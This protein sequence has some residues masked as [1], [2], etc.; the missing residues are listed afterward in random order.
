MLIWSDVR[1]ALRLLR[2]APGVTVIAV[3]S[4]ALSIGALAAVFTAV[5][6][7]LLE[8]LPYAHPDQLVIFDGNYRNAPEAQ[9]D[10]VFKREAQEILRRSRTLEGAGF[11]RNAVF[12]LG[13]DAN[14]PPEAL[15]GLQMTASVLPALGVTPLLGRNIAKSEEP[16]T[17]A[18]MI[19]SYGL[20]M[21][22]F[23]GDRGVVGRTVTVNGRACR[24]IGVMGPEFNF[25]LR[26]EAVRTP[27]PYVEF[28]A[29]M[30]IEKRSP[31]DGLQ[32][33][34][35]LK[36]GS[37]L[38]E[39]QQDVRAI[40]EALAREFPE[41]DGNRILRISRLR[42]RA[43]GPAGKALWLL[44]GAAGM[45]LLIGCAN[46]ASLLLARGLGRQREIA[47]RVALGASGGRI[48]R[49]LLTEGCVLAVLGGVAGYAVA[50]ASWWILPAMAPRTIPRLA[51][52]QA[53][54]RVL[55]FALGAAVLNGLLFGLA[56]AVRA[57]RGGELGARGAAT[58]RRDWLRADLIAAEVAITVTLVITGG[59]LLGSFLALL[60]IDPGFT[61]D[62]VLAAVVLPQPDRYREPAARSLVYRRFLEAARTIPGVVSAG[63]VDA[64]PFSGENDGG[65]LTTKTED[66]ANRKWQMVAE[67]DTIG[68][69]YLAT[70]GARLEEGRW[71]HDEEKD[72]AI[73]TEMTARKLWPGES[74]L[75]KRVCVSCTPEQ[76][77]NWKRVVGITSN[78]R[79]LGLEGEAEGS[80]FLA[81]NAMRRGQFLVIRTERPAG[82]YQQALRR[83]VASVEPQ[84][85][86]LL[87]ASMQTLVSDSLAARRFLML[88][89]AATGCLALALSA[90]GIYGVTAYTTSR[91]TQEI[92]IRMALGATPRNVHALVFRQGFA[93]VA[94]GLAIGFG[95]TAAA[96]R[97]LQAWLPGLTGGGAGD[98]WLAIAIVVSAAALACWIPSRRATLVDP[99][100]ALRVE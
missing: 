78:M 57:S 46:V 93:T 70:M 76:P 100:T 50:V 58:A 62:R 12:D 44:M 63:T 20:W 79:H 33:V 43:I 66:I 87:S 90:A 28:W 60:R 72:T 84:Q 74:A 37:T 40:S 6:A 94:V 18:E 47:I 25:P 71:F 52:A 82:E 38:A 95:I 31:Q 27:Q 36:P 2:R 83:A 22:R 42:D 53:D 85:P 59:R 1:V 9:G 67:V 68:G 30:S 75:G 3:L 11:W 8:P 99:M 77:D 69:D 91:R 86:V 32:M 81:A 14:T 34:A 23:R 51:D 97:A 10:W 26:R 48:V 56:P 29:P 89:L 4:T 80:I 65:F 73:V 7:V 49:Q 13:G 92:G 17:G 64:L 98:L 16:D 41:S 21:R 88:L 15:Y 24:I 39:A 19:L 61:Q 96:E 45:F 35:R 54:W 55:A 5:R